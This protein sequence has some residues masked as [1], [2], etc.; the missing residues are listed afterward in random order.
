MKSADE[1]KFPVLFHALNASL[2]SPEK[3]LWERW[4]PARL[5]FQDVW[6][7]GC[8]PAM[9]TGTCALP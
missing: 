6:T 1:G 8:A 3:L 5:R 7:P 2:T 9:I 4:A